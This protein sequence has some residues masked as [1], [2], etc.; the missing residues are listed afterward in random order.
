MK[1][2]KGQINQLA[3]GSLLIFIAIGW[4]VNHFSLERS[5]IEAFNG[6][7]SIISQLLIGAGYGTVAA[8]LAWKLIESKF[9]VS[10]KNFFVPFLG[11]LN[12]N[13]KDIVFI[14]ICAGF[15]EE[16]LFRASLQPLMGI[17]WAAL[18]FVALHGYLNPNNWRLSIYGVLMVFIAAGL[19]YLYQQIGLVAA[20]TAHAFVDIVLLMRINNEYAKTHTY[21]EQ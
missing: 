4:I 15:G 12:F 19:G 9:M 6:N 11:G 16:V 3:L 18:I 14:S 21:N 17:W 10:V 7:F 1:I 2:K 8:L 13:T 5:L 20:I